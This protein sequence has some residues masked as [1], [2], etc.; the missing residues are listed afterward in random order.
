MR[1]PDRSMTT[2]ARSFVASSSATS[3]PIR[4]KPAM[5]VWPAQ[6]LDLAPH[7]LV[8]HGPA[9]LPLGQHRDGRRRC[10]RPPRRPVAITSDR[11]DPL[12]RRPHRADLAEADARDRDHDHVEGVER[13]PA[14]EDVSGCRARR[15]RRPSLA[16]GGA[17]GTPAA[18][19]ADRA[20]TGHD[21]PSDSDPSSFDPADRSPAATVAAS[22]AKG[23]DDRRSGG[24]RER[25]RP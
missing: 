2:N 22:L 23:N 5:I 18:P 8:P 14:E 19:R 17:T 3:E 13:R 21:P 7:P 24:P 9:D 1:S 11:V 6:L 25:L 15:P 16:R 10:R 4:P 20:A 12:A